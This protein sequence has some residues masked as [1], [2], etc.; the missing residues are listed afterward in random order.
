M[1]DVGDGG[2]ADGRI[3]IERIRLLRRDH[4]DRRTLQSDLTEHLA[5]LHVVV[6]SA[7]ENR[8]LDALATGG[9][10]VLEQR[11]MRIIDACRPQQH[12]EADLQV[13]PSRALAWREGGRT[14]PACRRLSHGVF[15]C[16]DAPS[17][18][19]SRL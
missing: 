6:G 5:D 19:S 16:V 10:D 17:I 2:P 15:K 7:L 8:N 1:V 4:G 9:L 11:A 13:F 3:L 12:A 18:L 14:I